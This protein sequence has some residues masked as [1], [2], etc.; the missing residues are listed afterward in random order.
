MG[1]S[2]ATNLSKKECKVVYTE[3]EAGKKHSGI[4]AV[5]VGTFT[6]MN[7]NAKDLN[8]KSESTKSL[9]GNSSD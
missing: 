7:K 9:I 4:G 6:S 3:R 1:S 2:V 5:T 8:F